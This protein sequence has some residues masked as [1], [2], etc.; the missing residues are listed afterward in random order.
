MNS[1]ERVL[2]TIQHRPA[3]R[4]PVY[5]WTKANLEQP[6][7]AAFGSV[8]AFEDHYEFDLVHLFG[9]PN[10][11]A[12]SSVRPVEGAAPSILPQDYLDV[13]LNDPND[14]RTYQDLVEQIAHHQGERG[15]FVYV[16]TPGIFESLND[17]FGLQNH[18]LYLALYPEAL[19]LVYQRQAEWNRAFAMNCIDLGVD[20]IHVSDDW[21][22]Q[23]GLLFN[24]RTWWKLIYPNHEITCR[25]VLARG[26]PISLHSDG[27]INAV[28]DGVIKLGYQVVHPWQESAG[29]SLEDYKA[30][31]SEQLVVMGGLDVQTA[32]GFGKTDHLKSEI[33][34]VIG[35]FPDG[36][37][38]FCTTHF[39]QDHCS[40]EELVMAFDLVHELV[41]KTSRVAV[42]K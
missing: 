11:H 31:Y 9:G 33:E 18:L 4:M 17:V 41:H 16:Q 38:I 15:R 22:W 20:M 29:M 3:D 26:M 32:I 8:D 21:G 40:I 7:C 1:R 6:I 10:P 37:L 12:A 42:M 19:Q 27:N 13:P 28:I 34:R 25:A 35:M 14:Q 39:V 24:P 5:G 36:G 30:H 23:K 2:A